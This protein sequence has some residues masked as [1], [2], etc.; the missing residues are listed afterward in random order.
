MP[1][2]LIRCAL[3]SRANLAIVPMQD[4]LGLDGATA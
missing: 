4:L 3:G 1:W 2:P